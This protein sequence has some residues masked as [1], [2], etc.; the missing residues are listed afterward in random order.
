MRLS[1][2]PDSR[3]AVHDARRYIE[4][5]SDIRGRGGLA[6]PRESAGKRAV[7]AGCE[8]PKWA[9]SPWRKAVTRPQ[10]SRR[11]RVQMYGTTSTGG[12]GRDLGRMRACPAGMTL[13]FQ[14][15]TS[16][17]HGGSAEKSVRRPPASRDTVVAGSAKTF[18]HRSPFWTGAS[19]S[20]PVPPASFLFSR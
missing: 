16:L 19:G 6:L 3:G 13:L 14:H 9:P 1:L 12:I 15:F 18:F 20:E 7:G 2:S 8:T 4:P 11:S 10:I 17:A 5:V